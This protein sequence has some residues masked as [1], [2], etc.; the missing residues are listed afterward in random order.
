MQISNSTPQQRN[1]SFA[2][3]IFTLGR[4]TVVLDGEHSAGTD[5]LSSKGLELIKA[6]ISLGGRD[7][8][9]EKLADI[10]W[11]DAEAD[12]AQHTLSVTLSR[13]RKK[14]GSNNTIVQRAGHIS[15]NADTCWVDVWESEK[16]FNVMN[17]LRAKP[18][19]NLEALLVMHSQLMTLY[20]GAFLELENEQ[21]YMLSKREDLRRRLQYHLLDL[22]QRLGY[23]G[24]CQ[25]N[26]QVL[27]SGIRAHDDA[28]DLYRQL[29]MCNAAL[30]NRDQSMKAYECCKVALN[31]L[32]R[33]MPGPETNR[34]YTFLQNGD[35]QEI[36]ERCAH[37]ANQVHGRSPYLS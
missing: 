5:K 28:E 24:R 37:C 32:G 23:E 30:G 3:K 16:L 8:S 33:G 2:V 26:I 31:V 14:L 12:T 20:R 21:S 35:M 15:L 36:M 25:E 9:V 4:F 22:G 13:V 11:N 34:L 1:K 10:L 6:L 18:L 27:E 17:E 29:M 19:V 7:V